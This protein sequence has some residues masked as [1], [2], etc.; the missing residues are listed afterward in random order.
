MTDL[1]IDAAKRAEHVVRTFG[2]HVTYAE[3]DAAMLKE[4]Y[5]TPISWMA[6]WG[7]PVVHKQNC[8]KLA[9]FDAVGR[10]MLVPVDGGYTVPSYPSELL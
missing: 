5:F 2:G 9:V 1:T 6:G 10:G 3:F 7:N 4:R 8:D